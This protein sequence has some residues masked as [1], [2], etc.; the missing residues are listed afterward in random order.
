MLWRISSHNLY[1]LLLLFLQLQSPK[2][3]SGRSK[4][5]CSFIFHTSGLLSKKDCSSFC[6]HQPYTRMPICSHSYQLWFLPVFGFFFLVSYLLFICQPIRKQLAF[7]HVFISHLHF[8][9]LWNTPFA[10]FS[11][12]KILMHILKTFEDPHYQIILQSSFTS[13][14]IMF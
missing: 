10:C 1:V 14:Y 9:L 7:F 12:D 13:F 8:F 5:I 11:S 4:T 2:S 3:N 6:S